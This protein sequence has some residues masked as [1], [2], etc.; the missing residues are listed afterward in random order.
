M[1]VFAEGFDALNSTTMLNY[2][3]SDGFAGAIGSPVDGRNESGRALRTNGGTGGS[4]VS[5]NGYW[6]QYVNSDKG[7]V[8]MAF[9][10]G[11]APTGNAIL[12]GL[13]DEDGSRQC[14]LLLNSS[15]QLSIFRGSAS[16]IIDTSPIILRVNEWYFIEVG[17]TIGNSGNYQLRIN[18]KQSL[19]GSAD[20]QATTKNHHSAIA[21]GGTTGEESL[22]GYYDDIYVTD[23]LTYHGDLLVEALMP[24]KDGYASELW[25]SDGNQRRNYE[26]VDD[27]DPNVAGTYVV[28]ADDDGD[29]P[30]AYDLEDF[31]NIEN[32]EF[33]GDIQAVI[34]GSRH[35]DEVSVGGR[36]FQH[37]IRTGGLQATSPREESIQPPDDVT[38]YEKRWPVIKPTGNWGAVDIAGLEI[39]VIT[40]EEEAP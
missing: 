21:I 35:N 9:W 2:Y 20:T 27:R 26:M 22:W 12:F 17:F 32:I 23:D 11:G 1:I 36:Q 6:S 16:N 7:V 31:Y 15:M 40:L 38:Y 18:E 28:D 39:G 10:I 4:L 19:V 8:G 14:G 29:N 37:Q 13:L 30:T 25:G 3:T 33:D 24:N 34:V 5:P